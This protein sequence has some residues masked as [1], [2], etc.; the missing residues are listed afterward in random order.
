MIGYSILYGTEES[1][2]QNQTSLH[3]EIYFQGLSK[4]SNYTIKVAGFSNYGAG[5]FSFPIVCTTLQDV[6]DPPSDIKVLIL[7]STSLPGPPLTSRVDPSRTT[8]EIKELTSGRSY[9][10]WVTGSTAAGEGAPSRRA[11]HTPA[12]RVVA[13]VASL[14]GTISVGVSSSLLL[15]CQCVG[16]PPPRTVWYHKHNIIT[17]HP[18]FTRNHDDSLLINNIDQSLS[19]NY[20]CLAK[21]LYGSDSVEYTVVVLPLPEA[22]TLRATPYKDS[23]L[24]E[25]EQPYYSISNR[26]SNQKITY[27]LTWKEASGPW[28]EVWSPNKVPNKLS[29]LSGVQ[30]MR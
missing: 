29:N 3:T 30:N 20:T 8:A 2:W 26:S 13:G 28:Q 5:P 1:S 23:I 22:P 25:W 18:R 6:P 7:S 11:S 19:G 21:N 27:S 10:V 16:V 9:E 4:Y 12:N 14:G 15:V 24:V 17:H